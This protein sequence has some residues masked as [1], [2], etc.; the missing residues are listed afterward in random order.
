MIDDGYGPTIFPTHLPSSTAQQLSVRLSAILYFFTGASPDKSTAK[1]A[2]SRHKECF[3]VLMSFRVIFAAVAVCL[4]GQGVLGQTCT[5]VSLSPSSATA[6]AQ[7]DNLTFSASGTPTNCLKAAT[8]DV[9]WITISFGGGTSNPSTFGIT[10]AANPSSQSRTGAVTVNGIT[11]FTV[12]Q[13]GVTCSYNVS[14]GSANVGNAAGSGTITLNAPTGCNWTASSSDPWLRPADS[15]GSGTASIGYNYDANPTPASRTASIQVGTATFNVTQSA[16]CG[17]TLVPSSQT[18]TASANTGSITITATSSSCSRTALSDASWL[19]ISS[20]GS[21]TGNGTIAWSAAINN[22]PNDRV[23]HISVG[24][25]TFT[26]QQNGGN[27][28]YQMSPASGT[29]ASTG[30]SGTF[31]LTTACTWQASS[32]ADWLAVSS[33]TSGTGNAQVAWNAIANPTAQVRSASIS[34]GNSF[35]TLSQAASAC[36]VALSLSAFS[37]PAEGGSGNIDITAPLG[38]NWSATSSVPWITFQSAAIGVGDGSITFAVAANPNATT[39]AGNI[40]INNR[41]VA[42]TQP[43]QNCSV[44]ISPANASA[45]TSGASGSIAVATICAWTARSS[46]TWVTLTGSQSG[47][48]NGQV[49]YAVSVNSGAAIRSATIN[50]NGQ[51]FTLTQSGGN[52]SLT[53]SPTSASVTAAA[54]TGR[55][56]V[57]GS[58]GCSW[59]PVSGPAWLTFSAFSSVNG[60]GAVDYVVAA[61]QTTEIRTGTIKVGSETFTV[62]QAAA[63][64]IISANGVVN[65][66]NYVGGGVSPGLIV[67]VF[68][69][70]LGPQQLTTAQLTEDGKSLTK[71]LKTSQ[72]LFDGVPGAMIYA[73]ATQASAVVPYSV[74]GKTSTK[75]SVQYLGS[76]SNELTIP[77][78]AV[79]PAIFTLDQTG[80]GQGAVLN[81]DFT[82]NGAGNAAARNSVIQVFA[83]GE[84]ATTPV[85]V[86]AKLAVAPLPKPVAGVTARI[87]TLNAN[88]VYAGAAPGLVAG[89]IQVNIQVPPTATVG[90]AVPLVITM[91]TGNTQANVTIAIK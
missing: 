33:A 88:V 86:D 90:A 36:S 78:A 39:R 13:Q 58:Q 54:T 10:V 85:G 49:D 63:F 2:T 61:N 34:I 46:A 81:Q 60:S 27:C 53:L 66:A 14:P 6:K 74:A 41:T 30:G 43:G 56:N 77:V 75:V 70:F 84:G 38:C 37:A 62:T 48:G 69:I 57:Q 26:L 20:G 18:I 87:G 21:G 80:K 52:C 79:L 44:A 68:G 76:T 16:A 42:V 25:V 3:N 47:T 29:V 7:G 72:V 23:A 17:F 19:T 91:G 89:V 40:L 22:T 50:I 24:D 64:P 45:P 11:Q 4:A 73:S 65:A 82:V 55:L 83:T 28:V 9:P 59:Q 51:V 71:D 12:T 32:N 5:S 67:T 15:I 8:A 31:N 35:F 1:I